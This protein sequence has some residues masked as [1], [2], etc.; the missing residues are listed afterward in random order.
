ML[1]RSYQI[2]D[3]EY[4]YAKGTKVIGF[5]EETGKKRVMAEG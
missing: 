1:F 3:N 2:D 5:L 4:L